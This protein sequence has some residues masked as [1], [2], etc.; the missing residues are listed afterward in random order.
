M[1][2]IL[3]LIIVLTSTPTVSAG[4]AFFPV[5]I[6]RVEIDSADNLSFTLKARPVNPDKNNEIGYCK[7]FIVKGY[8]DHNRWKKYKEPMSEKTHRQSIELL[9]NAS[10]SNDTIL[11]GVM[12]DGLKE[13]NKCL[14]E[15]RGLFHETHEGKPTVFSVNGPI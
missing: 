14:F 11:L 1:R 8:Y 5:K 13:I 7:M 3:L 10:K 6:L 9:K 4:G 2:Y 12:G 15:S